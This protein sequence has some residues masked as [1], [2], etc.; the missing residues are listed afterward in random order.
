M[1]TNYPSFI[2]HLLSEIPG[3]DP[4]EKVTIYIKDSEISIVP[5]K[6]HGQ[7]VLLKYDQIIRSFIEKKDYTVKKNKSTV[8]RGLLGATLLGP[9]G[10]V[11]GAVSGMGKKEKKKKKPIFIIRYMPSSGGDVSELVF[12]ATSCMGLN[13]FSE[14]INQRACCKEATTTGGYL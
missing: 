6:A 8:G 2:V 11:I 5:H 9:T 4:G 3:F 12:D 1:P 10:A 7:G 13:V 14:L